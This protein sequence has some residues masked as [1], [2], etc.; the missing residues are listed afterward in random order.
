M[1]DRRKSNNAPSWDDGGAV[2]EVCVVEEEEGG[3]GRMIQECWSVSE[4]GVERMA[5]GL[6]D[7][8]CVRGE[9]DS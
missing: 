7:S 4:Q 1:E 8:G 2:Q 5:G 9:T 6:A 3:R